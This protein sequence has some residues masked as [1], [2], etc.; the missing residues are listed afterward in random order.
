MENQNLILA[1]EIVDIAESKTYLELVS[2]IC[3]YDDVN[4]ND[5]LLPSDTAE[6]KA[7]TLINMPVQ[8]KY[9]TNANG[10][11]TLGGHEMHKKMNGDVVFNTQSIGTHVSV[12]IENADVDVHGTVKNL[13]CLYAKYRIWKRYSNFVDAVVRLFNLG[14]LYGSWE[15]NVYSYEFDNGVKTIKDYE[16]L[17]N[18]LL[19]YEYAKP[20]YG[21]DAKAISL[22]SIDEDCL[23]VAALS[24]DIQ[25]QN[26]DEN[27]TKE[28]MDL[29]NNEILTEETHVSEETVDESV[30]DSTT[31]ETQT[32]EVS[33][34]VNEEGTEVSSLTEDDLR[35]EIRRAC[36]EKLKKWCWIS[37]HFPVDKEIWLEYEGRPSQLDYIRMTYSVENDVVTVSEPE[38]VKLTVAISQI[39]ATV[40]ELQN[41][42]A[43][44]DDA[45]IKSGEEITKLKNEV[46]ELSPYKTM[47]EEA[48]EKRLKDEKV[49]KEKAL[50][51]Q[52]TKSGLITE[53]EIEASEELKGYVA[54][55]DS[56][57]LKA[58]LADRYMAS[59]ETNSTEVSE[60]TN[61]VDVKSN[62]EK[63]DT[64]IASSNLNNLEDEKLNPKAIMRSYWS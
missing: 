52:I 4:A 25:S 53:E 15:I 3:Y 1:S 19:G 37:Y 43:T 2:R 11:K 16:F 55:L 13:P 28:N 39:N 49:E 30:N 24:E 7:Q 10:E 34:V 33:E 8:A 17:A 58:I 22:S 23:L 5:V 50:I 51:A 44:K 54:N 38:Y 63:N 48:E 14:K 26:N 32:E 42:I 9:K 21:I 6:E 18:T 46:A 20:S 60:V 12:W 62:D 61:D 59:L 64:E 40:A 47:V 41:E 57:S 29:E 35:D 45:I 27:E 56:K 31:S 36:R